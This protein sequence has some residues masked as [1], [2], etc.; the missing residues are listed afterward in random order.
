MPHTLGARWRAAL[1]LLIAVA[2]ALLFAAVVPVTP[3]SAEEHGEIYCAPE[4][5]DSPFLSR[6]E[7]PGERSA[8]RGATD[9]PDLPRL[10]GLHLLAPTQLASQTCDAEHPHIRMRSACGVYP[11]GPPAR[12]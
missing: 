4:V 9:T 10:G 1:A 7:D 12:A 11:R 2:T 8:P 6:Q 5:H 3:K